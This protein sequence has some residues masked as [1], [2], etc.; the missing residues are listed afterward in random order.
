MNGMAHL[1]GQVQQHMD[2]LTTDPT[3]LQSSRV[4]HTMTR[5]A[6]QSLALHRALMIHLKGPRLAVV[7]P[8]ESAT[9]PM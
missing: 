5:C 6:T 2:Q 9:R 4:F 7:S 3:D 1:F 8:W